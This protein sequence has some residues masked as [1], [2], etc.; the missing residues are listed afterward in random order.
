VL[1][2]YNPPDHARLHAPFVIDYDQYYASLAAST[3]PS[4]QHTPSGEFSVLGDF[5]EDRK[6]NIEYL[7]SLNEHKKRSRS[8]EED[9]AEVDGAAERK[10]ARVVGWDQG[11]AANGDVEGVSEVVGASVGADVD[12][13][14]DAPP[15]DDP[16]VYG[17]FSFPPHMTYVLTRALQWTENLYRSPRSKRT[18]MT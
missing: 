10:L 2:L 3:V 15:E 6:P 11:L 13:G 9:A 7:D 17:V 4:T 12:V 16:T 18:T 1:H 5:E 14:G 8:L